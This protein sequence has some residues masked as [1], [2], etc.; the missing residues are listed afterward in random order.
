MIDKL[1]GLLPL[2]AL[3]VVAGVALDLVRSKLLANIARNRGWRAAEASAT[4]LSGLPTLLALTL[5]VGLATQ[6]LDLDSRTLELVLNV[7]KAVVVLIITAKLAILAGSLIRLF[8]QR[9]DTPLSSSTIFVNLGRVVVWTLGLLTML[10][11]LDVS[12]TPLLTALGVAGLAVG[13]ALQPTL[14]NLFSGVQV[15]ASHQ[16][17]IGDFVR[18]QTG[19]EGWVKDVTWRN[20]TIQTISNDLIIAPNSVVGRS[21][22]VNFTSDD[23][24][25]SLVVPFGVSY[26]TDLEHAERVVRE[27][28]AATQREA[29]GAVRDHEPSVNFTAFSDMRIDMVAVLRTDHY[30]NRFKVRSDFLKRLRSRFAE[31]QIEIPHIRQALLPTDGSAQDGTRLQ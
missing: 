9:E 19:E 1:S 26:D 12:I 28:A 27:V 11:A 24:E 21:L 6:R 10:A 14:E 16:V 7:L 23:E 13:L 15:L 18:L 30:T 4:S 29:E 2:L 8:T 5:A 20:T 25:H 22:V 17:K 31:E 3:I